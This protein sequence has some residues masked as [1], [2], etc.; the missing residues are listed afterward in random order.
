MRKFEEAASDLREAARLVQG[1]PVQIEP[2]G[3]PNKLNIPLSSLQFN[4][5]YHLGLTYYLQ[6]DYASA[7]TAYDSCLVYS[8][9]PDLLCATIDWYYMT[10]VRLG[11]TAKA[12]SL[13][14]PITADMEI[15]ENDAY[16]QRLLMYKGQVP[17]EDL[18]AFDAISPENEVQVVTQGYGVANWLLS[19]GR[20]EEALR[21]FEAILATD[22]WPAFGYIAAEADMH[23]GI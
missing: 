16:H 8:T 13:L 11:D 10:A 14:E 18:L 9:N 3:L 17:P 23:R 7:A 6:G 15:I 20:K 4:I 12:R 21:V 22:Y 2:D 5:W 19:Q 1:R